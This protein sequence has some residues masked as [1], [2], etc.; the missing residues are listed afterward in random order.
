MVS[1][2]EQE[3]FNFDIVLFIR[4]FYFYWAVGVGWKLL[5]S[6]YSPLGRRLLWFSWDG[7]QSFFFFLQ[8][9]LL[10][11]QPLQAHCWVASLWERISSFSRDHS[12]FLTLQGHCLVRLW[13]RS[14]SFWE[15]LQCQLSLQDQCQPAPSWKK[16]SL[17]GVWRGGL[18]VFCSVRLRPS[19]ASASFPSPRVLALP[20]STAAVS[21]RCPW[22]QPTIRFLL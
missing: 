4:C 14:S 5:S 15:D 6:S 10:L 8:P 11:W 21:W 7:S 18:R 20:G 19:W 3:V 13:G 9:Q 2:K 1:F 12:C 16:I 17:S 22:L